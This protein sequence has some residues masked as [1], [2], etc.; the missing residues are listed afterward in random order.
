VELSQH[1]HAGGPLEYERGVQSEQRKAVKAQ[2]ADFLSTASWLE[3]Q[4]VR[5]G[6]W[7]ESFDSKSPRPKDQRHTPSS[8][9]LW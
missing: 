9:T 8:Y 6:I 4:M 3:R 5:I 1:F 2:Y 7:L